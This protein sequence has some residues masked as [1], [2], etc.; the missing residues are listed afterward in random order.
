MSVESTPRSQALV[1][2]IPGSALPMHNSSP[3]LGW[4]ATDTSSSIAEAGSARA[5][6]G[7]ATSTTCGPMDIVRSASSPTVVVK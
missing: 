4:T 3:V 1:C 2:P 6:P 7:L 5:D